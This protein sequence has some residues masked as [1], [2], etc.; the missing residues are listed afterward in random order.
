ML[1]LENDT[2][3]FWEI[4]AVSEIGT[5]LEIV[6]RLQKLGHIR[7]QTQGMAPITWAC[8]VIVQSGP[9]TWAQMILSWCQSLGLV[10]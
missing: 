6:P 10:Q 9:I 3:S 4:D 2:F 7:A 5:V 1:F 8:P